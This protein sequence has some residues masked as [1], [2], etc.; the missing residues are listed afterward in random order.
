MEEQ[1]VL[2]A[3][4]AEDREE[5]EEQQATDQALEV[6]LVD[7]V[8]PEVVLLAAVAEETKMHLSSLAT[9]HTKPVKTR[10]SSFSVV[11]ASTL[12]T[13]VYCTM[14]KASLKDLHS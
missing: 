12:L 5:E 2:V 11:K 3:T 6:V 1:E 10:S 4:R 13:Y 9:S 7:E 14:T 8:V